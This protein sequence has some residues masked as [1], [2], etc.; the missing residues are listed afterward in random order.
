MSSNKY[1]IPKPELSNVILKPSLLPAFSLTTCYVDPL[2]ETDFFLG[3][4]V[5]LTSKP[6]ISEIQKYFNF[7]TLHPKTL[8]Q[9]IYVL[10]IAVS[11]EA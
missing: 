11:F 10:S 8:V 5:H 6:F 4:F 9:N 3:P 7:Y 2:F 1:R